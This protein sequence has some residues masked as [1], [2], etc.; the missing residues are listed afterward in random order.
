MEQIVEAILG[1]GGTLAYVVIGLLAF[2]EAAAFVG[3][4]VPGE[5]AV[6]LGGVLA[7][8]GRVSLPVVLATVAVAA[9]AGDSAG[10]EIGRRWGPRLQ[11]WRIMRRHAGAIRQAEQYLRRRG[12]LMVFVGRWTTVLRAIVPGVA[13]MTR[14]PYRRFLLF[15][16]IGGVAWAVVFTLAGYVAGESYARVEAA[17][18]WGSW[19]LGGAVLGWVGGCWAVR[20]RRARTSDVPAVCDDAMTASTRDEVLI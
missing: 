8:Q 16:V 2:G 18:G 7:S 9:I 4:V 12:G 13:G 3:L 10:Y 20:R 1:L 19:L 15:N 5:I 11:Q 6:L 14:M 17:T